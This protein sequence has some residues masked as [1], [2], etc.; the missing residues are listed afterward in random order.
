M[1]RVW[2]KGDFNHLSDFIAPL[3]EIKHDP[4]NPW[5]SQI[6]DIDTFKQRT[7]YSRNAFPDLHFT[8]KDMI[9]ENNK[10]VAYWIMAGTHKGDLPLLLANG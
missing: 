3:Y 1:D 7:L 9:E 8:I 6:L 4:G 5:D 10:V 2:N